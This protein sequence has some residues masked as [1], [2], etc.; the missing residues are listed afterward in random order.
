VTD[1][2]I[3]KTEEETPAASSA[4]RTLGEHEV[5]IENAEEAA[6]AAQEAADDAQATANVAIEIT[7]EMYDLLV[8]G[9]DAVSAKLAEMDSDITDIDTRLS[10]LEVVEKAEHNENVI[11][12]LEE[13][14]TE[15]ESPLF[16]EENPQPGFNFLLHRG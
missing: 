2:I 14:V 12:P 11:L 10:S 13:P 16:V 7:R 8:A 6:E 15:I 5:K 4:E 3:I 1:E 9:L